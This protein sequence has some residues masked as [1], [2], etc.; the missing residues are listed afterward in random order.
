MTHWQLRLSCRR[1]SPVHDPTNQRWPYLGYGGYADSACVCGLRPIPVVAL[2][3]W[4]PDVGQKHGSTPTWE[5]ASEPR[6]LRVPALPSRNAAFSSWGLRPTSRGQ[7]AEGRGPA[8]SKGRLPKPAAGR[9]FKFL[10]NPDFG[11]GALPLASESSGRPNPGDL[12][13]GLQQGGLKC[14]SSTKQ[15]KKRETHLLLRSFVSL[16]VFAEGDLFDG[17]VKRGV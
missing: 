15:P 14:A 7:G 17:A 12:T 9:G 16:K 2:A 8:L 5:R 4:Q 11:D 1:R 10:P 13:P 3:P 6:R